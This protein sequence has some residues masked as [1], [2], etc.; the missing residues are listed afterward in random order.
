MWAPTSPARR[1]LPRSGQGECPGPSPIA[2]PLGPPTSLMPLDIGTTK[3][4][5]PALPPSLRTPRGESPSGDPCVARALPTSLPSPPVSLPPILLVV[6]SACARL[7]PPQTP[8]LPA[9][10]SSSAWPLC[11]QLSHPAAPPASA[12]P[13]AKACELAGAEALLGPA[14]LGGSASA[15]LGLPLASLP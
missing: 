3:A 10:P 11:V 5:P 14:L 1:S 9:P 4:A 13:T 7:P 6:C 15:V 12:P 2:R 8:P